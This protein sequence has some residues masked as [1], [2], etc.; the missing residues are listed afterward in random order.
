MKI[1]PQSWEADWKEY[2]RKNLTNFD[3][4]RKVM[5]D[6]FRHAWTMGHFRN[7]QEFAYAGLA[8]VLLKFEEA[9]LDFKATNKHIFDEELSQ[10]RLGQKSVLDWLQRWSE[11]K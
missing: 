6:A 8:A 10:Y 1:I 4:E 2:Y 11:R 9:D 3:E 7:Q 5:R